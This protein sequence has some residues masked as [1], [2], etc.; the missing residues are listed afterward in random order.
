MRMKHW[1]FTARLRL[2]SIL[3][4]VR[5]EQDGSKSIPDCANAGAA[6]RVARSVCEHGGRPRHGGVN[7]THSQ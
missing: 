1:W 2:R 3:R 4:R 6:L 7:V 5:M